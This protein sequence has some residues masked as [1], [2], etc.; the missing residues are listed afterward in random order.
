MFKFINYL[1]KMHWACERLKMQTSFGL[2]LRGKSQNHLPI[3]PSTITSFTP[4]PV[5]LFCI[6]SCSFVHIFYHFLPFWFV[7]CQSQEGRA[8]STLC[9]VVIRRHEQGFTSG[10]KKRGTEWITCFETTIRLT[11]QQIHYKQTKKQGHKQRNKDHMLCNNNH[12]DKATNSST[13]KHRIQAEW[14]T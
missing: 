6:F 10:A 14:V 7:C 11:R 13:N 9:G 2:S 4:T 3:L 1:A 8:V 5:F 12:T